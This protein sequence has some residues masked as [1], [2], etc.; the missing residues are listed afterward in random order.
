MSFSYNAYFVT[1]KMDSRI[2]K[3]WKL[4]KTFVVK[5]CIYLFKKRID[6]DLN[7]IA[8]I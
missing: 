3:I 8:D 4:K 7:K 5:Y 1:G 2:L 6:V